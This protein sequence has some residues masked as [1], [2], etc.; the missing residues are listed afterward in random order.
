[1]LE[2]KKLDLS[3]VF[4]SQTIFTSDER[5]KLKDKKPE[6]QFH[7]VDRSPVFLLDK[8]YALNLD[9]LV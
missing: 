5:S 3:N 2:F 7:R 4:R 8:R 1:M 6:Q 9:E